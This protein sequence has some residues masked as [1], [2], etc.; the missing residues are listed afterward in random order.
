MF[1][2]YSMFS[3][4]S[5]ISPCSP[6][7][8]GS[9]EQLVEPHNAILLHI[10]NLPRV[11]PADNSLIHSSKVI[12]LKLCSIRIFNGA[13]TLVCQYSIIASYIGP[14]GCYINWSSKN[15]MLCISNINKTPK[16]FVFL[17]SNIFIIYGIYWSVKMYN[18]LS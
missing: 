16:T 6:I 7:R 4:F 12:C 11:L 1:S 18:V 10:F 2:N 15:E 14:A 13:E 8:D 17:T 5:Q 3:I 9:M